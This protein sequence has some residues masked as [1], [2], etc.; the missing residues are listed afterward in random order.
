MSCTII[1]RATFHSTGTDSASLV[2]QN[3]EQG[4]LHARAFSAT[5][6]VLATVCLACMLVVLCWGA[7]RIVTACQSH[8][9]W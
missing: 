5:S 4:W 1:M 7:H 9:L 8:K 2:M 3:D 6:V